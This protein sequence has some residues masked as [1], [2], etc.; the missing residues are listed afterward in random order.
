MSGS[1]EKLCQ[2]PKRRISMSAKEM[3]SADYSCQPAI[4]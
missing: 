2:V 3:Q 4:I 1:C